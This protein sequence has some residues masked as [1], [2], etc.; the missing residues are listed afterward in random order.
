M[1]YEPLHHKY[2]PQTFAD[3]VGQE[4]IAA[5]LSNALRL[6]RIA[7][8]YLFTGA[9]GTGK[10][11]SA[12]IMAKSLNCLSEPKPTPTPCGHCELC[13][14]ITRGTAM[15]ITEIDAASNTGVDNIREL[16]ERAQ[17]APVQA[18]YK[19]YIIDEV[20]MLSN[21]AFNALLKTLEEPPDR[22]TFVLAT[23]DP[24]RVLPTII[25]RCQRFD[26]RRIPLEAMVKHLTHIAS[27]E[28]IQIH[29]EAVTLVA[30]MAQGGLRD[31]EA[32]LDQLS[33]LDG[34][35]SVDAVWDLVGSVPERDLL[36]I[37]AAIVDQSPIVM[38]EALRRVMD[39]G[40]EPLIVLQ[41]LAN[42]YRDLLIA[43]TAK[44]RSDLV[45]MTALGWAQLT[46]LAAQMEL[47]QI[48]HG[49]Q[50]LRGAETQL[51]QSTQPRLWLEVTLMGLLANHSLPVAVPTHAPLSMATTAAAKSAPAVSPS[52]TNIP[53]NNIAPTNGRSPASQGVTPQATA[54]QNTTQVT[55]EITPQVSPNP[56]AT[57]APP[58][59]NYV[60]DQ[61]SNHVNNGA[62][63][64]VNIAV[65]TGNLDQAWQTILNLLSAPSRGVFGGRSQLLTVDL[66]SHQPS[67]LVGLVGNR[68]DA[69][70]RI[71]IEKRSEIEAACQQVWQR[72]I[73]V[74][75]KFIPQ[76]TPQNQVSSV[77]QS[78]SLPPFNS[79]LSSEVMSQVT[80]ISLP[81]PNTA[82]H[83]AQNAAQNIAQHNAQ[84]NTPNNIQNN[85][86]NITNGGN[87]PPNA[88]KPNSQPH[89]QPPPGPTP[90]PKNNPPTNLPPSGLNRNLSEQQLSEK[91]ALDNLVRLFQGQVVDLEAIPDV[92]EISTDT[93]ALEEAVLDN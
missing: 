55:P 2:R 63:S 20:H 48:L 45:A 51:R 60:N 83:N 11:S 41:N 80:V 39:R 74:K 68:D 70:K 54:T 53:Y 43:K 47:P 52:P 69:M 13:H 37:L 26:F 18:R 8:A 17:F 91:N 19:V 58:P 65:D 3:L 46:E 14:S 77:P 88:P 38:L 28:N 57:V 35:I 1:G 61:V 29:P 21:A 62:D 86:Q 49:Q 7:P 4:A 50:H 24:Q 25:S 32:L 82:Q 93:L 84:T 42:V 36:G 6:D 9:R 12:R 56:G 23:T 33:L 71:A 79:S 16:I 89:N 59:N 73:Q 44:D 34:E 64:G 92:E 15:D 75:Y 85:T 30:Q 27:N 78:P 66:A 22:I 10:T 67:V 87:A 72:R 76:I 40:R 81:P 5:T 90:P 31:A